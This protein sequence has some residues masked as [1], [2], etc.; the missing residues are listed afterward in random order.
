MTELPQELTITKDDLAG[1]YLDNFDCPLARALKRAG[2]P[3]G[4]K[5]AGYTVGGTEIIYHQDD[6]P[7]ELVGFYKWDT[8]KPFR[9]L[10]ERRLVYILCDQ[11][12]A[13]QHHDNDARNTQ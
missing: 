6:S 2:V 10:R 7:P 5:D 1:A 4:F 12:L 9:V 3:I 13:E 8:G 11:F